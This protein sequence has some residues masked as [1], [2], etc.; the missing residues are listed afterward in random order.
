MISMKHYSLLFSI[1]FFIGAT[2]RAQQ[3]CEDD[4]E[5]ERMPAKYYDHTQPKYPMYLGTYSAQDKASIVKKLSAVEKLEESSRRGFQATGCELRSSFSTLSKT[6]FGNY[7]HASYSAQLAAYQNVCHV[8]QHIVKTVGEYRTVL[9][10]DVNPSLS[11]A[12]FYGELGDFYITDKSVRYE[13][14]IDAEHEKRN[15]GYLATHAGTRIS[16][17]LSESL[18]SNSKREFDNINN[19]TGYTEDTLMGAD[20][21]KYQWLNRRW[22]IT[23]PGMPL[24]VPVTRKEYLEALLEYYEV[25]KENFQNIVALK[26]KESAKSSSPEAKKRMAI[27]EADKAAYQ[28]IYD[29]KKD[30][31]KKMLANQS[32]DWLQKQAAVATRNSRPNDYQQ[33]SN[34]LF[35]FK[36]FENPGSR[37][38]LVQYNPAYFKDKAATPVTPLF[39]RV[40][41]RY[42][43]GRFFSE[44]LFNNFIKN[45]D[46]EALRK[47][48]D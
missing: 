18:V 3:P 44:T 47:M 40:Q 46:M 48:L 38:S 25:E 35:D 28:R 16:Q 29:A 41:F 11:A 7:F 22:Y 12:R 23:R 33:A 31:V 42:E 9:R 20:S 24:F 15:A 37:Q 4:K 14:A 21:K 45:Y 19:G 5:V 6:F 13:I 10:V 32:N 43:I 30:H 2:G 8:Q 39:F 36:Q 1:L 17:F 34:G 26:A 27:Y